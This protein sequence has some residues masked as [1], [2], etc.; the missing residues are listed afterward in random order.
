[1]KLSCAGRI[2]GGVYCVPGAKTRPPKVTTLRR[3]TRQLSNTHFSLSASPAVLFVLDKGPL[4]IVVCSYW[5]QGLPFCLLAIMADD[6][7]VDVLLKG[8]SGN[9]IRGLLRIIILGTIAA[10]AVSSRLFSVIRM[11]LQWAMTIN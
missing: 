2:P 7:P 10:A 6:A 9:N 3:S 5:H 4:C 8:R 1:M 11:F